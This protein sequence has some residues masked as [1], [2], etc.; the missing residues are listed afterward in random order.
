MATN[1]TNI[2]TPENLLQIPNAN[3]NGGFWTVTIFMI[4]IILLILLSSFGFEVAILVASFLALVG[5]VFLLYM[6]LISLKIMLFFL[7]VILF[8]ILYIVWS[9][10]KQ[11]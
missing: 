3:T 8:Y 2:T 5:S 4:W 9:S 10:S 11:N 7:G 6:G 1:W